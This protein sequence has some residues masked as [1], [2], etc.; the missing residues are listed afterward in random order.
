MITGLIAR[1]YT[2][3]KAALI[4]VFTHGYAAD[5]CVKRSSKESLLASEV[6]DKLAK[7]FYKLEKE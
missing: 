6:I 1:G 2:P 7:A 5:L 4:G 3:A